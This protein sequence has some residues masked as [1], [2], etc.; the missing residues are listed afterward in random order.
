MRVVYTHPQGRFE[1]IETTGRNAFGGT[2]SIREAVLTPE[3]D[4]RGMLTDADKFAM[5]QQAVN[6]TPL[7]EEEKETICRLFQDDVSV[8]EIAGY[9]GRGEVI[10]RR[11]LDKRGLRKIVATRRKWTDE[12]RK[13]IVRLWKKGYSMKAIGDAIDRTWKAV[14]QE[15]SSMRKRQEI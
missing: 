3:R 11:V 6:R 8:A 4:A 10:V 7:S 5:N 13:T 9:I 15:L 2:Y 12:E 1:V 14:A